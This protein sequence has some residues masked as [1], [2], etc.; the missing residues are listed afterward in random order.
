MREWRSVWFVALALLTMAVPAVAQVST[1]RIEVTVVDT[2]GAV[3]PGATVDLS[4]P[5]KITVTTGADGVARFLNLPPGVYTVKAVLQ[6][7]GD[8][9][10][11]SV[12]VVAGGTVGLNAKLAV[13]GMKQEVKVTAQ[14]PVIDAKKT[15]TSTNVTLEELQNIP[16]ARDPW[17]VMQT[18][19]GII[20]DRVNVGGSESGQQSG[21]PGEGR[22]GG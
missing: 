15:G 11:N 5:Q 14:T 18:V 17:V 1:G 9:V 20:V 16:S 8:Y 12:P 13:A 21:L 19:P 22:H 4:G 7:F 2:T 10:N 3:L 6:G